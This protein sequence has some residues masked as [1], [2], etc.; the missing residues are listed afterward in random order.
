MLLEPLP[1]MVKRNGVTEQLSQYWE[2]HVHISN[3]FLEATGA[4]PARTILEMVGT[5]CAECKKTRNWVLLMGGTEIKT[6]CNHVGNAT[7]TDNWPKRLEK[8]SNGIRGQMNQAMA[9]FELMQKLPQNK[10]YFAEWY[11]QIRE[12]AR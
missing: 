6:L 2:E 9:R 5:P 8:I 10:E 11:P 12:Q 3:V 7:E 1:L 4:I